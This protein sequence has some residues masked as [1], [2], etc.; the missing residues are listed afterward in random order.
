MMSL[1]VRPLRKTKAFKELSDKNIIT[2]RRP[3]ERVSSDF[4][5]ITLLAGTTNEIE[6]IKR[7]DGKQA[8][9]TN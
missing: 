8:Y 7:P 4:R 1:G 3:Y 6:V 9:N 2:V 5:R